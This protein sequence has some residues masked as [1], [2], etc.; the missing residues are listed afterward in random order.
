MTGYRGILRKPISQTEPHLNLLPWK[1]TERQQ[2][3][4]MV[5]TQNSAEGI[6]IHNATQLQLVVIAATSSVKYNFFERLFNYAQ[7]LV[8]V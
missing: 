6:H 5:W 2:E 7:W 4:N 1:E 3:R 8:L